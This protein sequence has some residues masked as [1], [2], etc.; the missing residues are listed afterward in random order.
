[1]LDR[2][3]IVPSS[4]PWASP[5]VLVRKP[6]G[7]PRLCVDYR[8]LNFVTEKDVFPLPR[9]A[10][11][12][13]R[14]GEAGV[15][16]TLDL[17]SGYWQIAMEKKSQPKTAFATYDGLYEFT[18]MPFGLTNA[19][20]TFQ[21]VMQLVVAGL[22][23]FCSVYLDDIVVFSRDINEHL[24]HLGQIFERLRQAGFKLRPKKCF[25]GKKE[26]RYLGHVISASGIATDGGKTRAVKEFPVPKNV[27]DL[28]SFLGLASYYRRF[29]QNFS[30]IAEPLY[31]L[32][33][34]GVEFEWNEERQKALDALKE[35]LTTAPV[36]SYPDFTQPF[37]LE[38]DASYAGLGAVLTQEK[39]EKGH[40]R[41]RPIA[42]ASRSLTPAERHYGV[43]ELEALAVVW[44]LR[45]YR[46][47]CLGYKTI[48]YTDHSALK[49]LLSSPNPSGKLARWGMTIQEI[50][51]EIRYRP[52]RLNERAD[53][54]SR[55]PLAALPFADEADLGEMCA[56][57]KKGKKGTPR[58]KP[59]LEVEVSESIQ[60]A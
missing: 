43:T 23:G 21:R 33:R 48:V 45:H 60:E 16:S 10:D 53:A 17:A 28:R 50:E 52:G 44:A 29:M 3:V 24:E 54:L 20:A 35:R 49:S 36:L 42:Y 41:S 31:T 55:S 39:M 51:P 57:L 1:M 9:I 13:D 18:K 32:L 22:D 6:D 8:R 46:V 27:K 15:Y 59:E 40:L 38:T 12:L 37:I 34:K 58:E 30:R 14:L 5:I 2:G 25:F 26:V 19:P 47:Y 4:S 56:K 7:S 11:L